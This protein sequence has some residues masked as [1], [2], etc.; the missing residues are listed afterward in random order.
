MQ[1]RVQRA[2]VTPRSPELIDY[3]RSLQHE[4][5]L[6]KSSADYTICRAP[7]LSNKNIE[8]DAIAMPIGQ[9]VRAKYLS[10]RA[11][12]RF[13]LEI[14]ERRAHIRETVNLANST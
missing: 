4:A 3:G 7:V 11:A 6:E 9:K 13:F 1:A 5:L 2:E 14:I 8:A 10:R 12:A